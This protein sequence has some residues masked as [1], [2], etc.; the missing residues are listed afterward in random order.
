M[1]LSAIFKTL[2]DETRLRIFGLLLKKELCVCDI[3]SILGISQANASRHLARMKVSGIL[4]S[5][6]TAQWVYYS[7]SA[8]FLESY[9]SIN[10]SISSELKKTPTY[11]SDVK[12]LAGLKKDPARSC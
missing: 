6:K 5:R 7:L 9:S 2:G 3:E 1:D 11:K 12:K 8:E 4:A 10:E